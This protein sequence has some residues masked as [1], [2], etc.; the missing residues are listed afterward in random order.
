MD[1]YKILN[2]S[3]NATS[4]EIKRQYKKLA[5]KHPEKITKQFKIIYSTI[6][7]DKKGLR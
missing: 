3:K 4:D 6:L 5:L 7:Y 1:Y 2:V